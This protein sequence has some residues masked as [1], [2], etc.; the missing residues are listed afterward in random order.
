MAL[1][2]S[3]PVAERPIAALGIVS[4]PPIQVDFPKFSGSLAQLFA[5]VREH[6]IDLLD[7]P[8]LPICEAYFRY[9]LA[10]E[11]PDLNESAAALAALAFLLERK[12]WLLLPLPAQP[13]PDEPE[14]MELAERTI[15]E[16]FYAVDFLR[17]GF[18]SRSRL[19]FRSANQSAQEYELP[20]PVESLEALALAEALREVIERTRPP[21]MNHVTRIGRA[22]ADEMVKLLKR[23]GE[24]WE[25]FG[26][27]LPDEASREDAVYVFLSL[28]ELMRL[29]QVQARLLGESI[30]FSRA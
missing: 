26:M 11:E 27:L 15:H 9:I 2:K 18:E 19:F 28:L 13:E 22:L 20:F 1:R 23:I 8:L 6:K 24:A 21:E 5:C 12:A 17:L 25:S 29:G 3:Y 14:A 7:V 4:P 16:Y 30:E 10:Q